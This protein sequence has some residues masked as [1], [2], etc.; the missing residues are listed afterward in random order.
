VSEM[1]FE[2]A[3]RELG[4]A[5]EA[6]AAGD[7]GEAG[8]PAPA[9]APTPADAEQASPVVP[10]TPQG[11]ETPGATEPAVPAAEQPEPAV[12]DSF[13]TID[14][15]QLPQ[16]L[17]PIYK[18]LQADYTRKTQE[19]AAWR[20]L[21]EETG[22]DPDTLR[23]SAELYSKLSDPSN[24]PALHAELTEALQEQG[25]SPAAAHAEAT[26]QME[27]AAP[28]ATPSSLDALVEQ[29][30]ELAPLVEHVKRAE[31]RAEALERQLQ[32]RDERAQQQA[33]YMAM[34]GELQRQE[35]AI[36]GMTKSDGTPIYSQEDIDFMYELSTFHN[37]NL[38]QAQQRFE[39][40]K[41]RWA[42]G[43]INSKESVSNSL[44]AP[45]GGGSGLATPA[46]QPAAD[47]DEAERRAMEELRAMDALDFAF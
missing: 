22:L 14:P 11:S 21:G 18:S 36:R 34:V 39:E 25:L 43:Y 10:S 6:D 33:E 40:M 1:S 19:A 4:D 35:S 9:P 29:D 45:V 38:L 24:W 2:D 47:L 23:T 31:A 7:G 26:R 16:E 5:I 27:E 15:S 13:T 30:P 28:A 20:K 37:G 17:Q 41:G 8:S 46:E 42:L 44:P 12:E 3:V 32:E